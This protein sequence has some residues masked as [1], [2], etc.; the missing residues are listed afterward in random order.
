MRNIAFD[1]L[2]YTN[3]LKESGFTQQQA[4][5]II[6]VTFKMIQDF[7]NKYGL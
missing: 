2:E 7:K 6:K 1:T 3:T 5:A 4:E